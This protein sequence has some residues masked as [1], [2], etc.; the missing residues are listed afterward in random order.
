VDQVKLSKLIAERS[1]TT[2][3]VTKAWIKW[4]K[5]RWDEEQGQHASDGMFHPS[6]IHGCPAMLFLN[7]VG[8]DI[9]PAVFDAK[10]ARIF[11]NGDAV[12]ERLQVQFALA[13]ILDVTRFDESS[14]V[15]ILDK[16]LRIAGHTDGILNFGPKKFTGKTIQMFGK[17]V[18]VYR[19]LDPTQ[20]AIL[21]IKSINERGFTEIAKFK[22]PKIEHIEQA[23]VYAKVLGI[24]KIVFIY[25]NKNQQLWEELVCAPEERAWLKTLKT[26]ERVNKWI[27]EFK[28]T[29]MI[30]K[31]VFDAAKDSAKHRKPWDTIIALDLLQPNIGSTLVL[32]LKK[33]TGLL[34]S[35]RHA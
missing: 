5:K 23:T 24:K 12:H 33:K 17:E 19:F 4:R 18:P 15:P 32:K 20:Q 11:D 27:K 13:G 34:R 22:K 7:M 16:F 29:K 21:E 25:E 35:K 26:I 14:E 2:S 9:P 30:P 10:A 8:F 31:G 3:P 28:A 1:A 6:Q